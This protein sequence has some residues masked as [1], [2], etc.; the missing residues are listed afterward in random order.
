MRDIILSKKVCIV[1]KVWDAG[2]KDYITM[3]I[4]DR[5][6][7]M[8]KPVI[9]FK[10]GWVGRDRISRVLRVSGNHFS[11]IIFLFI[12]ILS[13]F[14]SPNENVRMKFTFHTKRSAT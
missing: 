5:L 13:W 14:F 4:P 7:Q 1:E 10:D 8:L 12:G 9:F 6:R 3:R 2:A 11:I